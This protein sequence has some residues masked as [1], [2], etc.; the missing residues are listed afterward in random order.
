LYNVG[1]TNADIAKKN[2]LKMSE[3]NPYK[4]WGTTAY[5]YFSDTGYHPNVSFY[6][7][8]EKTCIFNVNPLGKVNVF[9]AAVDSSAVAD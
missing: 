4:K 2:S 6:C 9:I 3:L 5:N 8:K 1:L 7:Q